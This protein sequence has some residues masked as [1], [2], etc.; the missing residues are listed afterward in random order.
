MR[1]QSIV[2]SYYRLAPG[3]RMDLIVYNIDSFPA[4]IRDYEMNVEEWLLSRRSAARQEALADLGD[5]ES[6]AEAAAKLHELYPDGIDGLICNAGVVAGERLTPADVISINYFGAVELAEGC[7]DLL[8]KKQGACVFTASGALTLFKSGKYDISKI[9]TNDGDEA[10]IRRLID[11][12][13]RPLSD[14]QMYVV[15]KYALTNWMRRTSPG[16]GK[17]GVN[18]NCAAPGVCET[19]ITEGMPDEAYEFVVMG[20]PMPVYYQA[21]SFM[22]PQDMAQ[23][24]CF[25]VSPQAHGINGQLIYCDGGTDCILHTE[26]F[27]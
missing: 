12:F 10:R 27:L 19:K 16:W 17:Q 8:K 11:T 24:L 20:N 21:R 15:S 5:P 7:F 6:R 3:K 18:V 4:M 9:I 25:L 2:G 1:E 23:A 14:R 26:E 13:E 22:S